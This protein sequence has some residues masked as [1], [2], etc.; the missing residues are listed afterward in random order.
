LN[1]KGGIMIHQDEM[2]SNLLKTITSSDVEELCKNITDCLEQ[3]YHFDG[4]GFFLIDPESSRTYFHSDVVPKKFVQRLEEILSKF[5]QNQETADKFLYL[6]KKQDDLLVFNPQEDPE[7]IE[8]MGIAF[9]LSFREH[10]I[11][12]L[13]LISRP[14]TIKDLTPQTTALPS[15]VS[16]VSGLV[17]N[18]LSHENKDKKIHMLNLYQTVSSSMSYIGDLQELL[19][20]IA[21]IV[22]SEILCEECSVLF[23][24]AQNNEFEFFT[25][26]GETGMELLKERFPADRGIAGRALRERSTQV[27]NDVQSDP[28]F[29]G[30]IDK[31]HNFKT[32]SILAAPLI[33]GEE[34]V[35]VLNA[36][37]K[38][39]SKFFDKNDD[40]ILSAIADEVALAV[41]NARLF[42]Y[43]VKSYCKIRQGANS[44]KGCKR[45]LKSWTPCVKYLNL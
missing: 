21:S 24:D 12:T 10:T 1:Y 5:N 29:Y 42:D 18:A 13:A 34:P 43:V 44:C 33:A 36:I 2:N 26:V 45:P 37:N 39:E 8:P 23:Y 3:C 30:N 25:A 19:T 35:G 38:I 7:P 27:V 4:V 28:D 41:K 14:E 40:Q 6:A 17:A 9:P 31:D 16:V 20:T 15:F 32:K 22:T 11:G